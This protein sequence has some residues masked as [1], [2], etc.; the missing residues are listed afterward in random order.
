MKVAFQADANIDPQIWR[1]LCR[2]EPSIDFRG[3][4][5]VIPDGLPDTEVLA[6]AAESA[7]VLVSADVNTM[8]GHF[9][10]F[11]AQHDSPGLILIPSS[12]SIAS[13][14]DGLLLVWMHWTPDRMRSQIVW[15]P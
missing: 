15:L 9:K 3:F 4:V 12:R 11:V 10:E 13:V 8:P 5:G 7:R 6:L 14:I 1:G 2:R